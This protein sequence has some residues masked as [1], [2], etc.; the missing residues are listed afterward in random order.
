L[1]AS[2]APAVQAAASS[3]AAAPRFKMAGN[4]FM[5]MPNHEP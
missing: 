4:K 2:A 5:V 3:A 1:V